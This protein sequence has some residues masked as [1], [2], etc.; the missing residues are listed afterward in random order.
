[1]ILLGWQHRENLV[2]SPFQGTVSKFL[3]FTAFLLPPTYH[4]RSLL[5]PIHFTLNTVNGIYFQF[6]YVPHHNGESTGARR[7]MHPHRH[8][9]VFTREKH[10]NNWNYGTFL[11]ILFL[12]HVLSNCYNQKRFLDLKCIKS[13]LRPGSAWAHRGSL[14]GSS[15]PLAGFKR[16]RFAAGND[17]KRMSGK[18]QKGKREEGSTQRKLRNVSLCYYR[19]Y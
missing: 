3:N 17:G 2:A 4:C 18:R 19:V 7:G 1:M 5:V 11:K 10:R 15:D 8:T 6:A 14:Q 9:A 13:V 16:G 12:L